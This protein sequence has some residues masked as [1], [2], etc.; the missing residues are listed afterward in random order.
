MNNLHRELAAFSAAAW[1]ELEEEVRRTFKTHAA[2]RRIVDVPEPG[3][4]ELGG[5]ATGHLDDVDAPADD[6][7]AHVRRFQPFVELR[8]PFIVDRRQVDDVARGANDADWQPAKDA[9]RRLAHVE[10]R[11]VFEGYAAAGIAGL[12]KTLPTHR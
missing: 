11:T 4:V 8:V 9:A 6:V 10:G 7:V 12:R 2:A 3:G 1:S 5:V